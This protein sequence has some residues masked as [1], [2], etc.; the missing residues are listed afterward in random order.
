MRASLFGEH[1]LVLQEFLVTESGQ[2]FLAAAAGH[3][4]VEVD[5]LQKA[6]AQLPLMDFYAPFREHRRGWRA[7]ADVVFVVT[8]DQNAPEVTGYTVKGSVKTYKL[9]D[10]VP[11]EPMLMLHPAEEKFR[12]VNPQSNAPGAVIEE[13]SDGTISGKYEYRGADGRWKSVELADLPFEV[14]REIQCPPQGCSAST[15]SASYSTTSQATSTWMDQ[16]RIMFNTEWGDEEVRWTGRG[17][18]DGLH[19]A[20]GRIFHDANPSRWYTV[21]QVWLSDFPIDGWRRWIDAEVHEIDPFFDDYQGSASNYN[22][23]N[24]GQDCTHL[25]FGSKA[26]ARV[27]SDR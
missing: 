6:V 20:D 27:S 3:A 11:S 1:K 13:S 15:L 24:T 8:L 10:G 4:G 26:E 25:V 19:R 2:R 23:L 16:A 14:V 17:Y 5:L 12:R 7:T 21:N 18:D 9:A 22:C